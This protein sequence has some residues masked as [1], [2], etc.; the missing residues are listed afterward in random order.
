MASFSLF[1]LHLNYLSGQARAR[2]FNNIQ[3]P[4]S[5][6]QSS[7]CCS[8]KQHQQLTKKSS[9]NFDQTADCRPR[10]FHFLESCLHIKSWI[11]C[12]YV[13]VNISSSYIETPLPK[14]PKLIDIKW[15]NRF[16]FHFLHHSKAHLLDYLVYIGLLDSKSWIG[17]SIG[18]C[19][20]VLLYLI[21]SFSS[22]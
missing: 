13:H 7:S 2:N 8:N 9:I 16:E 6:L 15:S 1:L 12:R 22:V 17:S 3:Q 21:D 14:D 4:F 5:L 18:S 11:L 19:F 10:K 20:T